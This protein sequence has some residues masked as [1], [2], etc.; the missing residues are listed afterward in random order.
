MEHTGHPRRITNCQFEEDKM[1]CS[2]CGRE[3]N[4]GARYCSNCGGYVMSQPVVPV[5]GRL[6]RP[7]YG[8]VFAGVCAGFAQHFG[9]D[10]VLVRILLCVVVLFGCGTPIIGYLIAWIA[11]PNEPYY[12]AVPPV[13]PPT[14]QAP[15]NTQPTA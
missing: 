11:I 10:V 14:A 12:F 15:T 7:R 13:A 1:I 5:Y 9:W 3:L 6:V 4:Q 2:V 8:R